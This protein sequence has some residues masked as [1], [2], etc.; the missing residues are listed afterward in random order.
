MPYGL[1]INTVD[2]RDSQFVGIYLRIR[3]LTTKRKKR[4]ERDERVRKMITLWCTE[5]AITVD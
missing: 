1:L 2:L 5:S 4:Q 3:R